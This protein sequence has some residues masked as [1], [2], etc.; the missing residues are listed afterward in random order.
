MKFMRSKVVKGGF[1]EVP[2]YIKNREQIMSC[3]L[4]LNIGSGF[5]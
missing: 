3:S 1:K 5:G 2:P 4:F